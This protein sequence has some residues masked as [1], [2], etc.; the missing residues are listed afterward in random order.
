MADEVRRLE[1]EREESVIFVDAIRGSQQENRPVRVLEAGC[2]RNW[3]FHITDVEMHITGID[4]DADALR[5]RREVAADLDVGI[6]GD[7]RT[8]ALQS[9]AFD[10]AYCSYVLEHVEGA[11]AALDN[12]ACALRPGGRLLIRIPDGDSC[13]GWLAKRTPHKSHVWYRRYVQRKPHAG[14]PGHAPYPTVYDPV[15][16]VRGMRRWADT[17]GFK[18]VDEFCVNSYLD[19]FGRARPIA[20]LLVAAM[21][22]ASRG[23]LSGTHNNLGFV[24]EKPA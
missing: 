2:G 9:E 1:D 14:E 19:V 15:V 21:A 20:Q 23:R 18:I 22:K 3:P 7:L 17:R 6:V 8:V 24:M 12:I 13:F 10:A 11:E 16:S 5:L 4:L